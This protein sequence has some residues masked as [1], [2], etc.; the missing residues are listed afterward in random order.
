MYTMY[1]SIGQREVNGS[2]EDTTSTPITEGADT[3]LY[4][5]YTCYYCYSCYSGMDTC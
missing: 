4:M 1:P 3:T 5:Y 2:V